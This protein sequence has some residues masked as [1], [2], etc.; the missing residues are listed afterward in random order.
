MISHYTSLQATFL[1]LALDITSRFF[2]KPSAKF[3][4]IVWKNIKDAA[5]QLYTE[6]SRQRIQNYYLWYGETDYF[7]KVASSNLVI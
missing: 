4:A 7:L 3:F 2:Q 5:M 6:S 1:N